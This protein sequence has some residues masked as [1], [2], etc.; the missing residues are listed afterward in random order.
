M[1]EGIYPFTVGSLECAVINDGTAMLMP[2]AA[3]LIFASAPLDEL[4]AALLDQGIVG[5]DIPYRANCLYIRTSHHHVLVDTGFG[6]GVHPEM[7]KLVERLM[8]YGVSPEE[9]DRVIITHGHGDHIGGLTDMSGYLT[10]PNA[11]YIMPAGEWNLWTSEE[12]LQRI[13]PMLANFARAKLPPIYD[14]LTLIN[15][16]EEIFP[17]IRVIPAGGHTPAHVALS[18]TSDGE[19]LLFLVDA[20]LDPIHAQHPDWVAAMDMLPEEVV[21]T[22]E[23]AMEHAAQLRALTLFYHFDFPGLGYIIRADGGYRWQPL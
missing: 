17:G 10:F 12:A 6:G 15:G 7:G 14:R 20:L 3:K 18:I 4:D 13:D 9:I 23:Q 16:D 1:A 11:R 2:D 19:E 22:R 21:T 8:L 5:Y